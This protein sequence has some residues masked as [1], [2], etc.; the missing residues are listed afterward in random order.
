MLCEYE[1]VDAFQEAMFVRLKEFHFINAPSFMDKLMSMFKPFMKENMLQIV[2]SH[3][4]GSNTLN[5]YLPISA[6]PKDAGGEESE[7]TILKG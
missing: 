4:V 6:L 1:F 5:E 7:S 3:Q 2:H